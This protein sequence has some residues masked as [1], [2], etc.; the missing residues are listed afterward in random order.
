MYSTYN[1]VSLHSQENKGEENFLPPLSLSCLLL[2]TVR[3]H[4][5]L[6]I[7]GGGWNIWS[8]S[9]TGVTPKVMPL[10]VCTL[11]PVGTQRKPN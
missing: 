8:P 1:G 11:H 9:P 10:R 7:G 6:G 5:C 4:V 3:V 2:S